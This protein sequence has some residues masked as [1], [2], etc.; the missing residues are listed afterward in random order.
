MEVPAL[1]LRPK[2]TPFTERYYQMFE[3]L[4]NSRDLGMGIGYIPISEM[5]EVLNLYQ[6][7]SEERAYAVKMIQALDSVYVQHLRERSDAKKT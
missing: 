7:D 3:T 4:I 6:V 2:L 5:N 1:E